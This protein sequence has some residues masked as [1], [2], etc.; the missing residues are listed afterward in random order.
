MFYTANFG[1]TRTAHDATSVAITDDTHLA[2]I[3]G[4]AAGKV[5]AADA[6]GAPI[7]TDP[8]PATV[9]QLIAYA[10]AKQSRVL[11]A[12]RVSR[13]LS[14]GSATLDTLCDPSSISFLNS[15]GTWVALNAA[16]TPAP[17]RVYYNLDGS[18]HA[19][20]PAELAEFLNVVG[21]RVQ[22]TFDALATVRSAIGINPATITTLAQVEAYA[23]PTSCPD[24]ARTAP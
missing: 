11:A 21:A 5:I 15:L 6:T 17:T 3:Q 19:L 4:Q 12:L 18:S 9:A 1:F 10:E 8:P 14:D 24:P 7:L 20:T 13:A 16:A 23:W 22:A 2:L